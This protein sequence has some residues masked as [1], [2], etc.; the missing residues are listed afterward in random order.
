MKG[1]ADTRTSHPYFQKLQRIWKDMKRRN[2][3]GIVPEWENFWNFFE[4][5][6]SNKWEPGCTIRRMY[7][8]EPFGSENCYIDFCGKKPINFDE[9][10][11][12]GGYKNCPCNVCRHEDGGTCT[13]YKNCL[14]YRA[15]LHQSWKDFREA[16]LA[17][18]GKT[19]ID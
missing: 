13:M 8:D 3:R 5:A 14:Q 19:T 7:S 6:I 9:F 10:N 18:Y 2:R 1:K 4:W 11:V 17:M 12:K 16:A 15:W